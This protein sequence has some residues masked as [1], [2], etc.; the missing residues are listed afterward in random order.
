ML[1]RL[2]GVDMERMLDMNE[3]S[4][5]QNLEYAPVQE[6]TNLASQH[7]STTYG[8]ESVYNTHSLEDERENRCDL[9][10]QLKEI[11]ELKHFDYLSDYVNTQNATPG[12]PTAKNEDDLKTQ[13]GAWEKHTCGFASKM[14]KKWGMVEKVWGSMK[15]VYLSQFPFKRKQNL[16]SMLLIE[17]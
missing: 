16:E 5:T 1:Y 15:T 11:R 14:L 10:K 9:D 7:M 8:E 13:F 4:H 12:I 2:L 6:D 3:G 17:V